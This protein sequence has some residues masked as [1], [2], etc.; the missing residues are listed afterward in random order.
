MAHELVKLEKLTKTYRSFEGLFK[1]SGTG[2][3]AVDRADLLLTEG[4]RLGIVGESGSGKTTLAKMLCDLTPPTEGHVLYKGR[5]IHSDP[6]IYDEYR[7]NVQMVFQDPFS[8]LN[9]KLTIGSALSDGVAKHIT[10]D[11]AEI[12]DRCV[13]IME[14]VGLEEE[15]LERYPHEFSGG[16]RQRISIARALSLE[17]KVLV[18][19]E[20]VSSL[21][22]SVQAQILNLLKKLCEENSIT[23]VLISHDIAVVS[24]LCGDM[25]VMKDG[26]IVE[27]GKTAEIIANPAEEY[28][29]TLLE[30]CVI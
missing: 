18:A 10:Q 3:N 22:V 17:P 1:G 29:R 6:S 19:D 23:L 30:A 13:S 11:K 28:T 2:F 24:Y 5:D 12:R 14:M 15:H 16:Q 20:P 27:R 7:K 8:S 25:I 21:D 9:P 26:I 4:M